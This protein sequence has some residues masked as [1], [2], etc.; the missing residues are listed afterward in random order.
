VDL[1]FPDGRITSHYRPVVDSLRI[2]SAVV[3]ARLQAGARPG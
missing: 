1:G 2:A 3:R